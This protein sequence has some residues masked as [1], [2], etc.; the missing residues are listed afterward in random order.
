MNDFCPVCG[1]L[2]GEGGAVDYLYDGHAFRFCG[3]TCLHIFQQYPDVYLGVEEASAQLVEDS[4]V[5]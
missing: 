2:T 1:S 4:S 3:L 5:S